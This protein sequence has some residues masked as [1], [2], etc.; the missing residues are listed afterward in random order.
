MTMGSVQIKQEFC[1]IIKQ[2]VH[3]IFTQYNWWKY[4]NG[5]SVHKDVNKALICI[6]QYQDTDIHKQI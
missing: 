2:L 5:E 3:L 4:Y 1:I 6:S